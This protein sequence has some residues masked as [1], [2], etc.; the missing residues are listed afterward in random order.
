MFDDRYGYPGKFS[1]FKCAPCQHLTLY[2]KLSEEKI[3]QIYSNY[4]PRKG[5]NGKQ[6]KASVDNELGRYSKLKRWVRGVDNQGQF[7]ANDNEYVLDIGAGS[8]ESLLYLKCKNIRATGIE[9]DTNVK[10]IAEYFDLDVY[11]ESLVSFVDREKKYDLIIMNQVIEHFINPIDLVH[12]LSKLLN[13]NGRIL[14]SCPNANSLFRFLFSKL[15]INWHVPY[16]QHHFSRLSLEKLF[17]KYEFKLTSIRTVTPN[18]WFYFQLKNTYKYI[19]GENKNNIWAIDG[20]RNFSD[21]RSLGRRF[22]DRIS[23]LLI[24]VLSIIICRLIDFLRM[25]DSLYVEFRKR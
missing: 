15:W 25:G 24:Q 5:F 3:G 19:R 1:I 14:L 17:S 12:N 8:C 16:H 4:Y 2:P 18:L 11:I 20:T 9:A 6:I 10:D 22:I 23:D 7:D 21:R 13:P